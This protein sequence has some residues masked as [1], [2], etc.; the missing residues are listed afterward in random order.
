MKIYIGGHKGLLGKALFREL[1]KNKN[2]EIIT[3]ERSHLDLLENLNVQSN[4]IEASFKSNVKKFM[5][6]GSR[7]TYPKFVPQPIKE[8]YLLT[9]ALVRTNEVYFITKITGMKLCNAYDRA[10]NTD[11]LCIIPTNLYGINDN[12]H[13]E[14]AHDLPIFFRRFHKAK[15]V[16]LE[17]VMI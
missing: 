7:C 2:Y 13:L 16:N 17:E 8:E 10:S 5:S 1:A 14:N 15:E 11:Y 4:F 9:S 12:Y 3:R 6:L